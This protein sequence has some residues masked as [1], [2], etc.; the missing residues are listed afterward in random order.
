MRLSK[1]QHIFTKNFWANQNA[2]PYLFGSR[3]HDEKKGGD[4]DLLILANHKIGLDDKM[5]FLVSFF[6][7]FGEQKIDIVA[8]LKSDTDY[9]KQIALYEAVKL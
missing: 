1:E 8:Y 3:V 5:S 9:F 7:K 4:I 2:E 6:E